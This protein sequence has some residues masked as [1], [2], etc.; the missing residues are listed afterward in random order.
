M[1]DPILYF[2]QTTPKLAAL[3]SQ[4]GW[5]DNTSIHYEILQHQAGQCWIYVTFL[6][7]IMEGGGCQVDLKPCY[8]RLRLTLNEAGEVIDAQPL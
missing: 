3:C 1:S 8:G 7:S 5:I 6:E 2:L 4:N